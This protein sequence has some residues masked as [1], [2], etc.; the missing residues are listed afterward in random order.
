MCSRPISRQLLRRQLLQPTAQLTPAN[1][2][3]QCVG[4][5]RWYAEQKDD[6]K[7]QRDSFRGQMYQS[8]HERVQ[9]ERADQAR[10]AEHRESQKRRGGVGLVLPV[11]EL[12]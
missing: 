11:G 6:Q 4:G 5:V 3:A 10:F 8:T 2:A 9:R 1:R 12:G 7:E